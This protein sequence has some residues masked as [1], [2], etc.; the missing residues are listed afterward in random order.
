MNIFKK[1]WRGIKE[2]GWDKISDVAKHFMGSLFLVLILYGI[3]MQKFNWHWNHGIQLFIA[4]ALAW[5]IGI[6]WEIKGN[7]S[8]KDIWVDFFGCLVGVLA[9]IGVMHA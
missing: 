7:M 8:H 5:G 1:I 2:R 9:C 3:P 4:A 6:L